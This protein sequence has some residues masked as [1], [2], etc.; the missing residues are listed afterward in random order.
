MLKLY[1]E[2]R[3]LPYKHTVT[4]FSEFY[5]KNSG[6]VW[7]SLI[8]GND[9]LFRD[10]EVFFLRSGLIMLKSELDMSFL[11]YIHTVMNSI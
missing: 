6:G 7:L 9:D 3:F 8:M 10:T 11:S 4:R 2:M 5:K 1:L